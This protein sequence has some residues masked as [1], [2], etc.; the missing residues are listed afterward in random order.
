MLV[1]SDF[2]ELLSIFNDKK[3]K[4]LVIGG[5]AVIRYAEPRYTKDR[6]IR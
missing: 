3:V 1:N 4:Y 6:R 2:K 5:Y